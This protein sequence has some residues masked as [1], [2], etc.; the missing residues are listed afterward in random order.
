MCDPSG[1]QAT[2]W[3][4]NPCG[5]IRGCVSP[6]STWRRYKP[7]WSENARYLPYSVYND[8][9]V[10]APVLLQAE[11]EA[12]KIF[13][14][15]LDVLWQNCSTSPEPRG[16]GR[17]RPGRRA[18]FAGVRATKLASFEPCRASLD[19]A[20]GGTRPYMVRFGKLGLCHHRMAH[21]PCRTSYARAFDERSVW[22]SLPVR[23]RPRL[24]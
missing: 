3:A 2:G 14:R 12:A 9:G 21:P 8:A 1:N 19:W 24:L 5:N 4:L 10:S 20:S 18:Q 7:V 16:P 23:R 11:Q 15:G 22:R 6:V 13:D 17:P